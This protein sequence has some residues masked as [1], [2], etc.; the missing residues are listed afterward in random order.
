MTNNVYMKVLAAAWLL[1][2]I[3]ACGE[4]QSTEGGS[5]SSKIEGQFSIQVSNG[6]GFSDESDR[7]EIEVATDSMF[8]F[9]ARGW[10]LRVNP[11]GLPDTGAA[12]TTEFGGN[13]TTLSMYVEVDGERKRV[14]C[15][16]A[17]QEVGSF[18]RHEF[19]D[20]EVSGE[21]TLEFV[22]CDDYFSG[23]NVAVPGL[24]LTVSGSFEGIQRSEK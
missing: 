12:E 15:D 4:G 9:R 11:R 21:F 22:R 3:S 16:P 10:H 7:A 2:C 18:K 17:D 23:Q 13:N 8:G 6:S 24:P 5:S 1:L 20:T 19:T 14:G